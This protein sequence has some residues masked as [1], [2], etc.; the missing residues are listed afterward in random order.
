MNE[1]AVRYEVDSREITIT[2]DDVRGVLGAPTATDNEIR[3]FFELCKA[4]RL[5]PFIK[6]AYIIKYGDNPATLVV[7]KDVYTK[8]AQANPRFKGMRAGITFTRPDG[9]LDRRE[10]SMLLPGEDI[11]GGWCA[12]YVEGYE[13]PI[14]D[15]VSFLE[16][17]GYTKE[18][19][20]NR[21]WRAKPATMIRKVAIVHALR[22]AF[23]D[24]FQ[25]LYD[26]AEMGDTESPKEVAQ[27]A[28]E[29][30]EGACEAPDGDQEADWEVFE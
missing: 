11:L 5:D 2:A 4:Q 8:R 1:L 22:E 7:G 18:G 14:K 29:A 30:P 6:E 13:H 3:M 12:V 23:P 25:G 16:Y 21:Q 20:L 27:I 9:V 17:A 10:G 19:K 26:E 15:E 28:G 24:D